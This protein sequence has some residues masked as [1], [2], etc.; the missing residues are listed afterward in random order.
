MLQDRGPESLG[1]GRGAARPGWSP[2]VW[3]RTWVGG[4]EGPPGRGQG[5]AGLVRSEETHG[6]STEAQRGVGDT[7]G[8]TR[9]GRPRDLSGRR[10]PSSAGHGADLRAL[11]PQ[12]GRPLGQVPSGREGRGPL[13]RCSRPLLLARRALWGGT[14]CPRP[15][16][17]SSH[18][19]PG[20]P[21]TGLSPVQVAVCGR[22][23][24]RG[25]AEGASASGP[26]PAS[27]QPPCARVH[28]P[29]SSPPLSPGRA[30]LGP[31][32]TSLSV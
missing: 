17:A 12:E 22:A 19:G 25:G 9:G 14:A 28:V 8:H 10:L 26:D 24:H 13:P 4:A 5:R 27:C 6:A 7:A 30:F 15:H 11:T 1:C 29:A 32:Q 21:Y 3:P 23:P 16:T 31:Q 18:R 20:R 2:G